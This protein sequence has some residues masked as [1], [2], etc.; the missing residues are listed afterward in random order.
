MTK[1]PPA[2]LQ[3]PENRGLLEHG[4]GTVKPWEHDPELAQL[5]MAEMMVQRLG[6]P[7]IQTKEFTVAY[8]ILCAMNDT[9]GH[10]TGFNTQILIDVLLEHSK[11]SVNRDGLYFRNF[12]AYM[13]KPKY[14]IQGNMAPGAME[15]EK[16]SIAGRFVNWIRGG[17]KNEQ[18]PTTSN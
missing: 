17:K 13:M 4:N 16:Q 2:Q 1:E 5:K 8:S 3:R 18:Q 6:E 12:W 10:R 11:Q 9:Q 15:E 7:S 14:I